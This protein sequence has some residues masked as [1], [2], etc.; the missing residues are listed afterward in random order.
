MITLTDIPFHN[1]TAFSGSLSSGLP[2][3]MLPCSK[4]S[5]VS[6]CSKKEICGSSGRGRLSGRRAP[7]SLGG[8]L[9]GKRTRTRTG[10]RTPETSRE[11]LHHLCFCS[12]CL[13]CVCAFLFL[14]REL[15]RMHRRRA[16]ELRGQPPNYVFLFSDAILIC[17]KETITTAP[18]PLSAAS[19]TRSFSYNRMH[20]H[21]RK[22]ALIARSEER[23]EGEGEGGGRGADRVDERCANVAKY[24]ED[25]HGPRR[26]HLSARTHPRLQVPSLPTI[27]VPA[28]CVCVAVSASDKGQ[29][30]RDGLRDE[31]NARGPSESTAVGHRGFKAAAPVPHPRRHSTDWLLHTPHPQRLGVRCLPVLVVHLI[32][33]CLVSHPAQGSLRPRRCDTACWSRFLSCQ[34]TKWWSSSTLVHLFSP[35]SSAPSHPRSRWQA[36]RP[37]SRWTWSRTSARYRTCTCKRL[38]VTCIFIHVLFSLSPSVCIRLLL[39]IV[40]LIFGCATQ[41]EK[42]EWMSAIRSAISAI[43]KRQVTPK[44][45]LNC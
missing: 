25:Q 43:G 3:L 15:M 10:T 13:L 35:L 27:R 17:R 45:G 11:C 37:A 7:A 4:S 26:T 40:Q 20:V 33:A 1:T 23:E 5:R 6:N 44:E 2:P 24:R 28:I 30:R 16:N 42:T 41:G 22:H 31:F 19:C 38:F 21:K 32:R 14:S 12:S 29:G 8:A 9:R 36:T 39:R 18:V 34:R